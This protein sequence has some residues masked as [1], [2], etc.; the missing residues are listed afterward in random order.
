MTMECQNLRALLGMKKYEGDLMRGTK[1]LWKHKTL[2]VSTPADPHTIAVTQTNQVQGQVLFVQSETYVPADP[3]RI[4]EY[5]KLVTAHHS[6]PPEGENFTMIP[7]SLLFRPGTVPI[8]T[9]RDPRLVVPSAYRVLQAMGLSH[10]AGR[11]NYL[12]V[13]CHIWNRVLYDYYVS[14][15]VKPI[16]VAADDYM[17]SEDFVR[18]IC[19][20]VGLD[21]AKAYLSWPALTQEEREKTHPK[22]Y[23]SQKTM[24]NS[25]GIN[26]HLA[27][28]N[29]DFGEQQNEW[30][31]EFGEDLSLVN[32]M[33]ELTMPHYNYLYERRLKM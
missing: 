14:H 13:T 4:Y 21:P 19:S 26:P 7:D 28:R 10:G 23:A 2:F 15:G 12:M 16:V 31:R 29:T 25:S 30:E 11:N 24:L 20:Q 5:L 6:V 8:F 33:V 32:E 27:A 1:R 22:Y 9:L 17:T 3:D 18:H